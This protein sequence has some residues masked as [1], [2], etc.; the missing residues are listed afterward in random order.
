MWY[1]YMN[2]DFFLNNPLNCCI[3]V[4]CVSVLLWNLET[5][6]RE[7][8]SPDDEWAVDSQV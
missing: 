2:I 5:K 6:Q 3:Y 4:Q 1:V 8:S 7:S